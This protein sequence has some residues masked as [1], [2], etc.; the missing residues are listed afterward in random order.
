MPAKLGLVSGCEQAR[1]GVF[2]DEDALNCNLAG[3]DWR[4]ALAFAV[5]ILGTISDML[6]SRLSLRSVGRGCC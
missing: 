6:S 1:R 4:I 2:G 3:L 5:V